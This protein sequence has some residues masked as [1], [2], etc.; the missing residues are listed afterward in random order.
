MLKNKSWINLSDL[1]MGLESLQISFQ[2]FQNPFLKENQVRIYAVLIPQS[3]NARN[4]NLAR[5]HFSFVFSSAASH[6]YRGR[7]G[8]QLGQSKSK[9]FV[10]A[11]G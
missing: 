9:L 2:V 3:F 1:F 8:V 10:K 11:V 6:L 5:P 4:N 7:H